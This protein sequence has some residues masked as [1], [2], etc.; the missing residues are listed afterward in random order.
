VSQHAVGDA[1]HERTCEADPARPHDD[2]VVVAALHLVEDRLRGMAAGVHDRH[3]QVI[4]HAVGRGGAH[5][6][7]V[8]REVWEKANAR[9]EGQK[10]QSGGGRGRPTNALL[11]GGFFRCLVCGESMRPKYNR[12]TYRC[13]GRD[14]KHNGC[15][16]PSVPRSK[17]D[18]A[19]RDYFL[20]YVFDPDASRKEFEAERERAIDE[21]KELARQAEAAAT[22]AEAR[23]AT[24]KG[25]MQDGQLGPDVCG[26]QDAALIAEATER[27]ATAEMLKRQ[28]AAL[29][30]PDQA[31]FEDW[32]G[33]RESALGDLSQDADRQALRAALQRIFE[34]IAVG[35]IEP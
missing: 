23:R 34:Y 1:A 21:A 24:I 33:L 25:Y 20:D 18:G 14:E 7:I 22:V 31:R 9:R 28:A 17:V 13:S 30:A 32:Q 3:R 15:E 10:A 5:E 4:G 16:L 8:S 6:P 2:Q 12:D 11:P 29:A 35:T 19:L 27:K 26:E